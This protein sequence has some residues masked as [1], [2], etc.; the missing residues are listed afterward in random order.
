ME[1]KDEMTQWLKKHE[2]NMPNLLSEK[3]YAFMKEYG[4]DDEKIVA[5]LE[6][7]DKKELTKEQKFEASKWLGTFMRTS[8][9]QKK[10][11]AKAAATRKTNRDAKMSAMGI[12][13]PTIALKAP[14]KK[15]VVKKK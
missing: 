9:Y 3:Q 7:H 10:R 8:A 4:S 11:A 5:I 6:A 12:I 13:T 1:L 15:T 14:A 2:K